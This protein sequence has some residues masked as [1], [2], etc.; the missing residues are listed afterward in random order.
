MCSVGGP[1]DIE[2]PEDFEGKP[3]RCDDCGER[4]Q[5]ISDIPMCPA[6]GSDKIT[7]E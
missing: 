5:S 6:C 3:Y 7:A 2:L 4:F 1:M